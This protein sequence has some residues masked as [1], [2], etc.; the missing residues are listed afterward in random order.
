[1]HVLHINDPCPEAEESTGREPSEIELFASLNIL[2]RNGIPPPPAC[3]LHL[4]QQNHWNQ[5]RIP[6][7]NFF[8]CVV[9]AVVYDPHDFTHNVPH[10]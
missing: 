9:P 8:D 7:S 2:G 4:T 5:I 3:W 10:C 6:P 1:V